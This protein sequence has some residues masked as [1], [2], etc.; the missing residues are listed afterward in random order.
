[1]LFIIIYFILRIF[2]KINYNFIIIRYIYISDFILIFFIVIFNIGKF[3]KLIFF[4]LF[5][6][7]KLS[8]LINSK[9]RI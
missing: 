8:F 4:I 1:L 2:Y 3:L 9:S 5:F 6:N 7:I